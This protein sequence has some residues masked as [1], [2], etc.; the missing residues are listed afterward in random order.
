MRDS[1]VL[2][3]LSLPSLVRGNLSKV[4]HK[5]SWAKPPTLSLTLREQALLLTISMGSGG[6]EVVDRDPFLFIPAGIACLYKAVAGWWNASRAIRL[7]NR[8]SSPVLLFLHACKREREDIHGTHGDL[9]KSN[10][11]LSSF[12]RAAAGLGINQTDRQM[13]PFSLLAAA[14]ADGLREHRSLFSFCGAETEQTALDQ[15][16]ERSGRERQQRTGLL[17]QAQMGEEP[18][19]TGGEPS[20]LSMP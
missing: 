16:V 19:L 17:C 7:L 15:W 2:Q 20:E 13:A 12:P 1:W 9:H 4:L 18:I 8:I 11:A 6:K 14:A 3:S 10:K 5:T